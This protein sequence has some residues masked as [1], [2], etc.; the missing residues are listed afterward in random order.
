MLSHKSRYISPTQV[1]PYRHD[2]THNRDAR[3]SKRATR[4]RRPRGSARKQW[5]AY[6]FL[7]EP[8]CTQEILEEVYYKPKIS[9]C[10][11]QSIPGWDVRLYAHCKVW[12]WSGFFLLLLHFFSCN[13]NIYL[14]V[15]NSFVWKH[16][17][18]LITPWEDCEINGGFDEGMTLRTLAITNWKFK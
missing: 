17:Y 11:S 12:S 13:I 4:H 10:P 14:C 7:C 2:I 6:R 16:K 3:C 5:W 15:Y 18:I 8:H 9:P 1:S